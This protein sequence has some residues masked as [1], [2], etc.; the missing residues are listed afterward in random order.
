[1]VHGK[2]DT[3]AELSVMSLNIFDLLN[4]KLNG[5][6]KLNPCNDVRV[7]GYSK[8]S[9][10]IVGKVVVTCAHADTTKRCVFYVTDLN[11]MKI[12]LGLTFCKA[13]NLVKILCDDDCICKKVSVV[14]L[15]EVP[16]GLDITK[17]MDHAYL[18]PV[19]TNTKLRPDCKA[20]M[21]AI[22]S[23]TLQW[24]RHHERCHCKAR[25]G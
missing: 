4:L 20:H 16:T 17:Q 23:R 15:N 10:K 7:I 19:D 2:Q 13:F 22:I 21:I 12:L 3:G 8:Q 5:E 25:H 18:P 1:M 6:L 24:F 9:V 14:V 11:D